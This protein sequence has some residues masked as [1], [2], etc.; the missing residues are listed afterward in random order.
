MASVDGTGCV[1]VPAL[2]STKHH[3]TV[4]LG[5]VPD[6]RGFGRSALLLPAFAQKQLR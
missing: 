1:C 5:R 4:E 3:N 6:L 2:I